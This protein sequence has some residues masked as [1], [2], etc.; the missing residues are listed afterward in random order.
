MSY[1]DLLTYREET[2]EG[3]GGWTWIKSDSGAWDGPKSDWEES[4]SKKWFTNVST[5]EYCV[6]AG[7]N[8]GVYPRLLSERFG[9]VFTFEPDPLN[10]HCLVNNC[11]KDNIVKMNAALGDRRGLTDVR[12]VSMSNTGMH[13]VEETGSTIPVVMIDD[14]MLPTCGLIALDIEGYEEYALRG[15]RD[16]IRRCRPVIVVEAPGETVKR[17]LAEHDY[18]RLISSVSDKVYVP[19]A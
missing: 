1:A 3:I 13:K 14:L 16:T 19:N 2:V 9:R 12:R 15:A 8:H 11:Q 7:G 5:W 4:H 17:I 18:R 10:F 6:Q